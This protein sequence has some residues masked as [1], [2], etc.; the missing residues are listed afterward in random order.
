MTC[1]ERDTKSLEDEENEKGEQDKNN[2]NSKYNN[3]EKTLPKV[4]RVVQ[5]GKEQLNT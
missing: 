2:K 5:F 3:K 1:E 4:K